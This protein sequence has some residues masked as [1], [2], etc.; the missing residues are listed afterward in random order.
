MG[1]F[2]PEHLLREAVVVDVLDVEGAISTLK[3]SLAAI[4]RLFHT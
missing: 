4:F 2:V 3:E 1:R